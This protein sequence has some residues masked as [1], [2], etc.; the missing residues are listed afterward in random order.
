M[1]SELSHRF[2]SLEPHCEGGI[3]RYFIIHSN[4]NGFGLQSN[5]I[6]DLCP[7]ILHQLVIGWIGKT[8]DPTNGIRAKVIGLSRWSRIVR[9][10]L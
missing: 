7:V 1:I 2:E 9:E 10:G 3:V 6:K 4:T 8:H 5:A